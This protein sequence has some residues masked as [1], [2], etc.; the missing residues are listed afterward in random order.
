MIRIFRSLI[1]ISLVLLTVFSAS[2][3]EKPYELQVLRAKDKTILWATPIGKVDVFHLKY[4]HSVDGTPVEENYRFDEKGTII[5]VS[6]RFKMIGAGIEFHPSVGTLCLDG[7]WVILND[8]N[9]KIARYLLRV[10]SIA[11]QKIAVGNS[12]LELLNIAHSGE[13]VEICIKGR[14]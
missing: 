14:I 2:A 13:L 12:L 6:T 3:F 8:I 10:G 9:R 4:I 1:T 7:E 11:K 5:I